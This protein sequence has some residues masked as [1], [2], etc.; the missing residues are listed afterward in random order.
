M[1]RLAKQAERAKTSWMLQGSANNHQHSGPIFLTRPFPYMGVPK[2]SPTF[3][4]P[5][6]RNPKKGPLILGNLHTATMSDACFVSCHLLCKCMPAY[7]QAQGC[8]LDV[9]C[10]AV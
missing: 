7:L 3:Y 4:D 6:G 2:Q 9:V 8:Q 1:R 5:H 10:Q